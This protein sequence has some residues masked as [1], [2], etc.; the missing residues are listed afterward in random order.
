MFLWLNSLGFQVSPYFLHQNIP[1]RLASILLVSKVKQATKNVIWFMKVNKT[2]AAWKN[3]W[4]CLRSAS[5]DFFL[6]EAWNIVYGDPI[7]KRQFRDCKFCIMFFTLERPVTENLILNTECQPKF[8]LLFEF[9][10]R[11]KT[12]FFCLCFNS[13]RKETRLASALFK[14]QKFNF[15]FLMYVLGSILHGLRPCAYAVQKYIH[16][17]QGILA[18]T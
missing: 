9:K 12:A 16:C 2:P 8:L 3:S 14:F 5:Y 18:T 7:T 4:K 1:S 10:K 13:K 17:N 15:T 6:T 11:M